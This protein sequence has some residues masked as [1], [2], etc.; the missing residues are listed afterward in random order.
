MKIHWQAKGYKPENVTKRYVRFTVNGLFRFC[1]IGLDCRYDI[2][3]GVVASYELP[4]DVRIA[5]IA[6]K[7][8]AFG[9][10]E[11]PI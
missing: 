11:W 9:Y 7:G 4:E 3:Q 5:A 8:Q 10:V 1:E 2:R 6:Q